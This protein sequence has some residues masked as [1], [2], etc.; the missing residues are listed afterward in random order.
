MR[1][2]KKNE[3]YDY[4][5][6][7]ISPVEAARLLKL[8]ESS[9]FLLVQKGIIPKTGGDEHDYILGDVIDAYIEYLF[10]TK[11]LKEAQTELIRTRAK[12]EKRELD[13]LDGELVPV[14]VVMK[15]Y[16]ENI[17]N[18]RS[19]LLAIP[20]KI[21]PELVGKDE[22]SMQAKLKHEI[23][24]ILKELVEYDKERVAHEAEILRKK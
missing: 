1:G 13:A 10:D 5:S 3:I 2:R 7:E 17:S 9:F 21:A 14:S 16:T 8:P 19:K 24:E 11:G 18:V 22:V 6:D 4:R 12:K 15:V 20:T 23:Y